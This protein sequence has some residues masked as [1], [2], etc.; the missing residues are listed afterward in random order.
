[1]RSF[2]SLAATHATA[3]GINEQVVQLDEDGLLTSVSVVLD[4]VLHQIGA[5]RAPETVKASLPCKA[6]NRQ[7]KP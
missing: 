4:A 5:E 6:R 3:G 1:M 7:W 2:K